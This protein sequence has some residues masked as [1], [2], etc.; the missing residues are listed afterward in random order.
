MA[1]RSIAFWVLFAITMALYAAIV[2]W[3]L[4]VISRAAGGLTPFDIRPTGYSYHDAQAFLTALSAGG[5]AFY[6]DIQQRL[7]LFYPALM[8]ATLFF[9]IYLLAPARWGGW[10]WVLALIAIPGAVFDYLENGAVATMLNL[11]PNELTPDVVEVSS[12]W[13]VAKSAAS[14]VADVLL[15]VLLLTWTV[16]RFL[17]RRRPSGA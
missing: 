16:N 6:L 8:S 3:S 5:K 10:R 13:T 11:G 1:R 9:A 17:V 7:D 15:L 2:G 12:R 14:M 4:P